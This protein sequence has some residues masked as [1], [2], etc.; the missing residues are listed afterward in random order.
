M[1]KYVQQSF[2]WLFHA[3]VTLAMGKF[4]IRTPLFIILM[5]CLGTN[6]RRNI[7]LL[8]ASM[9]SNHYKKETIFKLQKPFGVCQTNYYVNI[10]V[11]KLYRTK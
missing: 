11:G 2:A 8:F 6:F 3:E 4:W 1:Y 10:L 7:K 9:K 5:V